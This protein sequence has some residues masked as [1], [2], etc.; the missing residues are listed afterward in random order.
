MMDI[1]LMDWIFTWYW[2]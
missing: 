1:S 2:T